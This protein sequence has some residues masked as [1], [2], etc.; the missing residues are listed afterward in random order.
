MAA[1][2]MAL[3]HNS[4]IRGYN[5]IYLQAPHVR[6]EDVSDFVA[7]AMT[8]HKFVV[9]HHDDEEEKLFPD[10]VSLLGDSK[11]WGNMKE[12]HGMYFDASSFHSSYTRLQVISTLTIKLESFLAGLAAFQNHLNTTDKKLR[13]TTLLSIMDSFAPD[14][15]THLH[16]EVT[17]MSAMAT[18]PAAPPADSLRAALARDMLKAW[19]KNTVTKAGYR[20]VLPFFLMNTDRTFENGAWVK[21]PRM[22]EPIRWGMVNL[23][24]M[25]H[26]SRWRFASCDAAGLPRELFALKKRAEAEKREKGEKSEL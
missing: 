11:I 20:D 1:T 26:G 13:P 5:S 12:E 10:M 7:Y 9:S 24:G 18:H 15:E 8:W 22:P 21:W 19:G 25:W 6:D 23:V 4:I 16:N 17:T 3:V 2:H 14:L